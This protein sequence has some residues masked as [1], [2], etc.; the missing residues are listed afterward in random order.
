MTDWI[1]FENTRMEDGCMELLVSAACPSITANAKIYVGASLL[2][3]LQEQVQAFLEEPDLEGYWENDVPGIGGPP[4]ITL[5]LLPQDSAGKVLIEIYLELNDGG[6]F[7]SH[8]CRFYVR[9]DREALTRFCDGLADFSH[10][11]PGAKL[12]L[13]RN[14]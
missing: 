11:Q 5:K 13:N 1:Q 7:V 2:Q 14:A 4:C 9:T 10:S 6:P 3:E 8:N 12:T